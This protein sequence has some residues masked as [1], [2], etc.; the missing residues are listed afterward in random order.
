MYIIAV[1]QQ[2]GFAPIRLF[3]VK[4]FK[5]VT[6]SSSSDMNAFVRLFLL[7]SKLRAINLFL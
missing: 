7:K 1:M 3:T 5:W 2:A 6:L 4:Y